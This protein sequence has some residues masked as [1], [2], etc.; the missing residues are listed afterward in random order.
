MN[1]LQSSAISLGSASSKVY[2]RNG[3]VIGTSPISEFIRFFGKGES[4]Y[5][6]TSNES[7]LNIHSITST[8]S[9]KLELFEGENKHLEI[10]SITDP[11][12][13]LDLIVPK[14]FILKVT[15]ITGTI[16]FL[17]V[18]ASQCGILDTKSL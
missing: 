14:G 6:I 18:M 15:A 17:N 7:D 9:Y 8:S 3:L 10:S 4:T 11:L 1:E 16:S 2:T 13:G 5:S 12:K